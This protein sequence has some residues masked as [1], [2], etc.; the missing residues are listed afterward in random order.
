VIVLDTSALIE[1]LLALPLS[2][3]VEERLDRAEWRVAAPQLQAVEVLQVLRRRVGAGV[4]T[5]VEAERARDLL[6]DLGIRPFEHDLLGERIWQLRDDLTAYDAS[7]V[8]LAELLNVELVT[9][10]ARLAHAP[11]NDA[12]VV[13]LS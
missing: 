7:Y 4:T 10:D 5:I 8:A 3:K 1:L 2:R 11:G 12:R 9:T 13:L 6:H